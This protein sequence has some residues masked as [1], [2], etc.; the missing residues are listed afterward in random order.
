MM[1]YPEIV[2][3]FAS[4]PCPG[5]DR[6]ERHAS[7]WLAGHDL[8]RP[9]D[10]A[11]LTLP[12]LGRL[13]A[14]AYPAA[15][16]E[17]LDLGA[18]WVTWLYVFDDLYADQGQPDAAG[19]AGHIAGLLDVLDGSAPAT[20]LAAALHD[21]TGRHRALATA[22]QA[23]RFAANVRGY[24]LG[25][26][27]EVAYRAAGRVPT[28]AQYL[29]LRLQASAC[30]PCLSL[31]EIAQPGREL[32]QREIDSPLLA[33]LARLAAY[34]IALA[35]DVY[36][37]AREMAYAPVPFIFNLPLV[38][39]ANENLELPPAMS[40]AATMTQAYADRLG[41]E[42]RAAVA[43]HRGAAAYCR[44]VADWAQGTFDWLARSGRYDPGWDT[45]GVS[46][47]V[48]AGAALAAGAR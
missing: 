38:L 26:L 2:L 36:S 4:R 13:A 47:G 11:A 44:G 46:A 34:V 8:V 41:R 42:Y 12:R 40:R 30:L 19:L 1:P 20:P 29:P 31:V 28:V 35:N 17:V 7:D 3:P 23:A 27:A 32:S 18:D 22:G 10:P 15:V 14:F 43:G 45:D 21:L 16:P 33:S 5:A 37:C 25:V 9:D 24:L 48:P 6:A 39:A